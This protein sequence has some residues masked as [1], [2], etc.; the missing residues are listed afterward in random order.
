MKK[1]LFALPIL[2]L[3]F[4]HQMT[5]AQNKA[6]LK[7]LLFVATFDNYDQWYNKAFKSDAIRRANFCDEP[8]TINAMIDQKSALIVLR[9]FDMRKMGAFSSDKKMAEVMTSY[10]I[11][12]PEVYH[13]ESLGPNNMPKGKSNLM[14]II[15]S[16][17]YDMWAW[18][19]FYPDSERR[20]KFCNEDKTRVA[21]INDKQSMVILYDFDLSKM[22]EFM[23]DDKVNVLIKKHRVTH[24]VY[25]MKSL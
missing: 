12:H 6:N 16:V 22:N 17:D 7:D 18:D 10:N 20:S 19:A 15:S 9:D 3:L 1:L 13:I 4:S 21:K 25:V 11:Q 23:S 8:N 2:A 14:F 5:I 24:D